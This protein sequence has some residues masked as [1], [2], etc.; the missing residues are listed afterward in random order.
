MSA[1]ADPMATTGGGEIATLETDPEHARATDA[2]SSQKPPTSPTSQPILSLDPKLAPTANGNGNGS[3]N[4]HKR[5]TSLSLD[6]KLSPSTDTKPR[7]STD[8]TLSLGATTASPTTAH[9]P[10]TPPFS[11]SSTTPVLENP[12]LDFEGSVDVN[13]DV[14]TE[15][16]MKRVDDLVVLDSSG[17]S[18]PFK[19]LYKGE[20]VAPR[21]LIIFIR[22]FF[23]GNCQEYLRELSASITPEA[24]LALPDPTFITVVGCGKP[25]LIDMYTQTTNCPFPIYADPTRKLYDLLNMTRT[26]DLGKK[27]EYIQ[28]NLF[29][30]S[31][32]SIV[33]GLKTGT[34]ALKGGDFKQVGGEFLFED[35]KCVWA[36]RM[37]NT[38]DHAEVSELKE[39]LGLEKTK[40]PLRKRWSHGVRTLKEQGRNRSSSW[41]RVGSKSKG[42]K[43]K[44]GSKTPEKVSEESTVPS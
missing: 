34:K 13:N 27:P 41:G 36:H 16:D 20:G 6:P 19:D 29:V 5:N 4:G 7:Q 32:Q 42:A 9:A 31:V 40:S 23:C 21:Q 2:L 22:H 39:L 43:D 8:A 12:E 10:T 1:L 11:P 26:F 3:G 37:R 38:R 25:D 17:E 44:E 28:S 14:P 24:L 18:R 30:T 15:K 33:Q 35:G